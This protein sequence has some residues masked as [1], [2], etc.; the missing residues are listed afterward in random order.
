MPVHDMSTEALWRI[1][2]GG[3]GF[4]PEL[5]DRMKLLIE[6]GKKRRLPPTQA[7]ELNDLMNAYD[8]RV[9]FRAKIITE[10]HSRGEDIHGYLQDYKPE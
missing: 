2:K 5:D 9:L 1:I 10:L 6:H 8:R 4:P 7:N 3:L